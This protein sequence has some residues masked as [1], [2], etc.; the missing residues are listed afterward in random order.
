MPLFQ[1]LGPLRDKLLD[2]CILAAECG[3][4]RL[5]TGGKVLLL[6]VQQRQV[7]L[8]SS[9]GLGGLFLRRL[10]DFLDIGL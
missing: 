2:L 3:G 5:L 6:G 1:L 10:L 7:L 4:E 8:L 9:L